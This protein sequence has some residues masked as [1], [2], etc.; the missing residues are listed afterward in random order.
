MCDLCNRIDREFSDRE[1]YCDDCAKKIR[2]IGIA[3]EGKA[4]AEIKQEFEAVAAN[5]VNLRRWLQHLHDESSVE[6]RKYFGETGVQFLD[7]TMRQFDLP[8]PTSSP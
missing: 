4:Y 6:F 7:K 2:K 8:E 5:I 1:A 3:A